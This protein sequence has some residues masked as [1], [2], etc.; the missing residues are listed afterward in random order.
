MAK[1]VIKGS[2]SVNK[3]SGLDSRVTSSKDRYSALH[4]GNII[5]ALKVAKWSLVEYMEQ[6]YYKKKTKGYGLYKLVLEHAAIPYQLIIISGNNAETKTGLYLGLGNIP[7]RCLY[8]LKHD[9]CY[10]N[11]EDFE[12]KCLE[13][14][15]SILQGK[16]SLDSSLNT[17]KLYKLYNIACFYKHATAKGPYC[18]L[19]EL[20]DQF[21]TVQG[22]FT[23]FFNPGS[24]RLEIVRITR[25]R[26][27]AVS[28]YEALT[29]N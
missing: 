7:L 20:E 19:P 23:W 22:F 3:T 24:K 9:A 1:H 29:A 18:S 5:D 10:G 26:D 8:E 27:I 2:K 14:S 28:S 13:V 17:E 11:I 16:Y 25:I 12:T 21:N 15:D 4:L 6:E